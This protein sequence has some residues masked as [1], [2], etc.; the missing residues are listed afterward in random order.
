MEKLVVLFLKVL[1][2]LQS[3]TLLYFLL[4]MKFHILA[5][6]VLQYFNYI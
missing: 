6:K 3:S 4:K 1:F 2:R 5:K